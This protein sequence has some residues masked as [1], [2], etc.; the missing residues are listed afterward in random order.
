[1]EFIRVFG[2]AIT[3]IGI[4]SSM[5]YVARKRLQMINLIALSCIPFMF[6]FFV[7]NF[8]HER[9][10]LSTIN[11][12][13]TLFC[14]VTLLLNYYGKHK[15]AKSFFLITSYICFFIGP[16][17]FHNSGQYYLISILIISILL[18]DD[19]RIH[20]ISSIFIIVAIVCIDMASPLL[21]LANPI[22]QAR[23][24]FNILGALSFILVAINFYMQIIYNKM[25]KIEDQRLRLYTANQ[26]KERIFSII[27]HDIKSPFAT[28]ATL[29]SSL[30]HQILTNDISKDFIEQICQKI[31]IQNEALDDLLRWGSSNI[32]GALKVPTLIVLKPFVDHII[33]NFQEQLLLKRVIINTRISESAHIYANI[34]QLTV[35]LRN[36]IS[37]SIKFSY[38]DGEIEIYT[39]DDIQRTYIHIKD[40]GIGMNSMKLSL[41]FNE[42]QNRSLGTSNEPGSGL[43]LVLCR[44]LIEQNNGTISIESKPNEGSIFTI[45]LP[46]KPNSEIALKV[47]KDTEYQFLSRKHSRYIKSIN[48]LISKY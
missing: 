23:R 10:L 22:P 37:N 36:L 17:L 2:H 43:G 41:L 27:A 8:Y 39:S 4:N 30:N 13:N 3:H 33:L 29:A 5:N 48:E 28:L 12:S 18:Y 47:E 32:K 15:L 45:G 7:I 11:I 1:M 31:T 20:I 46:T 35:I 6:S 24:I 40:K 25:R 38:A 14:T 26:D 34:D 16:L 21:P 9:Y 42:I 19:S 44:D